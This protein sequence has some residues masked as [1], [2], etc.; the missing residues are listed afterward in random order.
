MEEYD[1]DSFCA[2]LSSADEDGDHSLGSEG[3][4]DRLG[5][6]VSSSS[7]TPARGM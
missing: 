2:G 7:W 1:Y 3:M 4:D 6:E 5:V